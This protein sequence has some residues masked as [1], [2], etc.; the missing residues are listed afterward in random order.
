MLRKCSHPC[1]LSS[2]AAGA[3]VAGYKLPSDVLDFFPET[4]N[5]A[6]GTFK[7]GDTA[8]ELADGAS[9]VAHITLHCSMQG[10]AS[11]GS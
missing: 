2:S 9:P 6:K 5:K 4:V 8:A 7:L 3:E 11:A 1:A 10:T